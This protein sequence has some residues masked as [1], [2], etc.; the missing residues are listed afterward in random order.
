VVGTAERLIIDQLQQ[1]D[2]LIQ[3][4][5]IRPPKRKL[6]KIQR[7]RLKQQAMKREQKVKAK[8]QRKFT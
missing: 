7:L 2:A 8:R 1:L 3:N 5:T 4:G 6:S